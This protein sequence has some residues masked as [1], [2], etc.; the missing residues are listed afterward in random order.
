M[1][2]FKA[3]WLTGAPES[4]SAIGITPAATGAAGCAVDKAGKKKARNGDAISTANL[5]LIWTVRSS[6]FF[7]LQHFDI[8]ISPL[9]NLHLLRRFTADRSHTPSLKSPVP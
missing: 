9:R 8:C 5:S 3:T 4:N 2:S 7:A 6:A 1:E